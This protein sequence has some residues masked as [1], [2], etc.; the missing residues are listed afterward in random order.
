M[1]HVIK[2]T[3]TLEGW[4]VKLWS[5]GAITTGLNIYIVFPRRNPV[6]AL[7]AVNRGRILLEGACIDSM[8]EFEER[9]RL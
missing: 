2:E 6:Q 9:A 3:K 4:T 5:D 1:S 8:A 7:K